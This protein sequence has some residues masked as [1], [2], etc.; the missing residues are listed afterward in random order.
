MPLYVVEKGI[1][2][3]ETDAIVNAANNELWAGGGVCGAIFKE[4][5]IRELS[6][7]CQKLSPIATGEAVITEGFQL[8]AKYIIHAV[9]PIYKDGFHHEKE[10]LRNAYLNSLKLAIEH[11]CTSISFPLISSGIYGYPKEE[12][13]DV[14]I[15]TITQFLE[16]HELD[17]YLTFLDRHIVKINKILKENITKYLEDNYECIPHFYLHSCKTLLYDEECLQENDILEEYSLDELINHMDETFTEMLLR[18]IDEKNLNDINV[19]KKANM[20]RKLFSKIRSQSDYHPLKKTVLSLS[21]AMEL[22]LDETID[23][24]NKA[25]Y[26][27]SNSQKS[28]VI[29][30]YFIENKHYNI[31]DINLTLFEFNLPTL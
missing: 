16:T 12:A 20:D 19:Y 6:E 28:D 5:G 30:R 18:L 23:L 10:L 24:L 17:V 25:G 2:Q 8:K 1:T 9:G 27:L 11:S 29:I 7:A 21:I 3:M 15:K 22:S 26:T 14:A 31:F 13:L 4:A